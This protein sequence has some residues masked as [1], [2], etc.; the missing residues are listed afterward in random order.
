MNEKKTSIRVELAKF[1]QPLDYQLSW[2]AL[3]D[4]RMLVK[5]NFGPTGHGQ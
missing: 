5:T 4:A 3:S 2:H 1:E